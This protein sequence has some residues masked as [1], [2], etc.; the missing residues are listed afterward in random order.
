M[1]AVVFI[2]ARMKSSRFPA[3]PLAKIN[4]KEMVLY[5]AEIGSRAVGQENTYVVTD[6]SEI[7]DLVH[8]HGFKSLMTSD[9]ALTGTDRLA[10]AANKVPADIYINLQGDEPLVNPEDILKVLEY[11]KIHSDCVIN[12]MTPLSP[13][14][15]PNDV[16][17]PKVAANENGDLLYMSRS[18]LPGF[19]DL[20]K[21]PEV[22]QKQ[23]CIY[24]FNSLELKRFASFGRK[25]QLE[26][27]EDIEILRFLE[28]G[29]KVKMLEVEKASVA[30]DVPEDIQRVESL[31]NGAQVNC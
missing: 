28:M 22:V 24:A 12:C 3:K 27:S 16:N 19:K 5:V 18:P 10:E 13:E 23:V 31:L 30:V 1:H 9:Q 14:E 11:K 25:S 21:R 20:S 26:S 7:A 29:I 15:D 6:H 17:I 4:E 8:Q 2:P